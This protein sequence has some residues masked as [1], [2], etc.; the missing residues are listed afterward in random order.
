MNSLLITEMIITAFSQVA[1][2]CRLGATCCRISR[3]SEQAS[4]IRQQSTGPGH[5]SNLT[6]LLEKQLID[7]PPLRATPQ[8]GQ[9][10]RVVVMRRVR[11]CPHEDKSI[12]DKEPCYA[13]SRATFLKKAVIYRPDSAA[14]LEFGP[15][16]RPHRE[17]GALSCETAV[18]R[19]KRW[20]L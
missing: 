3:S 11:R 1:P 16:S 7:I 19:P 10:P 20:L 2:L 9:I 8:L 12:K 15:G 13:R 17:L 18:C 4:W 5:A 14:R 6:F